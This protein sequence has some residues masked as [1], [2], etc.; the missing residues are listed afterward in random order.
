[1]N[2]L[3]YNPPNIFARAR[4]VLTRHV[5]E[6]SPAKTGEY[7]RFIIR[8]IDLRE[9]PDRIFPSYG[10]IRGYFPIFKTAHVANNKHK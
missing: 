1:M 4:L 6:Y 7:P 8:A 3:N 10:N 9:S 2:V 5:T